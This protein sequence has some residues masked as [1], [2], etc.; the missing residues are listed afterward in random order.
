MK[1]ISSSDKVIKDMIRKR[2]VSLTILKRGFCVVI[3]KHVFCFQFLILLKYTFKAFF[4]F[5]IQKTALN[6]CIAKY[7]LLR[8]VVIN[9]D[10]KLLQNVCSKANTQS[11]CSRATR[12][13]LLYCLVFNF[14]SEIFLSIQLCDLESSVIVFLLFSY[15][16]C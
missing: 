6:S 3:F 1:I 11:L 5:G 8:C 15:K 4:V 14:D 9:A 7:L 12:R 10:F 2:C 13:I 16:Q